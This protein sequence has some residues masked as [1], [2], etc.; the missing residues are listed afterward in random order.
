MQEDIDR[1]T[2]R[3]TLQETTM[4]A[5]EDGEEEE[6]VTGEEVTSLTSPIAVVEVEAN[7]MTLIEEE[8]NKKSGM[9]TKVTAVVV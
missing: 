7:H 9:I 3:K 6:E 5:D 1:K 4:G 8:E 2:K